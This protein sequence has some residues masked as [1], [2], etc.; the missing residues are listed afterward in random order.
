MQDPF[1]LSHNI[2]ANIS[3]KVLD[4]FVA[5]CKGSFDLLEYSKNPKKCENKCWGLILLMTKKVLPIIASTKTLTSVKSVFDRSVIKLKFSQPTGGDNMGVSLKKSIEFVLYVLKSFL[6]FEEVNATEMVAQK[7]KR[8]RV[9]NQICDKVDS[10]GLGFSPKRL[11][12]DSD[13]S[14]RENSYANEKP[15]NGKS[16]ME[17]EVVI[18]SFQFRI[19]NSTWRGRRSVKREAKQQNPQI[20]PYELEKLISR[21]LVEQA[22]ETGAETEK[23]LLCN[24]EFLQDFHTSEKKNLKIIVESLDGSDNVDLVKLTTLVHFLEDYINNCYQ[25]FFYQWEADVYSQ[26]ND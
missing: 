5:E 22:A 1:D 17:N 19:N 25:N 23:D 4:H 16:E 10:L 20:S 7:R 9:L 8:L 18:S 6:L 26:K 2:S 15:V 14:S 13:D 11:K 3:Q 21:K 24:V 12:T